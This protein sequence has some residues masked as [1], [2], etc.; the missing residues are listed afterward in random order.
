MQFVTINPLPTS[1]TKLPGKLEMQRGGSEIAETDGEIFKYSRPSSSSF[2]LLRL[3]R[4]TPRLRVAFS[5]PG[6]DRLLKPGRLGTHPLPTLQIAWY[7]ADMEI[8]AATL[9]DLDRLLEI[10]GTLESTR[11]LHLDRSGQGIDVSWKIEERPLRAKLIDSNP[12]DEDRRFALKQ[13]L[14]EIE[15]GIALALEHEGDL[16]AL[17]VAQMDPCAA[18]R[19]C[20]TILLCWAHFQILQLIYEVGYQ[21]P[22]IRFS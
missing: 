3:S 7:S 20:D 6:T 14:S 2:C 21:R 13:V 11:Y 16:A 22:E 8:R 1:E 19:N 12:L 10:D 15:D 5:P 9:S 18:L 17:A 4:R